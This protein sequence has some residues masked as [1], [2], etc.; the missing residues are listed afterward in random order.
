ML[1]MLT[2]VEEINLPVPPCLGFHWLDDERGWRLRQDSHTG[3]ASLVSY[4]A[5]LDD[6]QDSTTGPSEHI[7]VLYEDVVVP[8]ENFGMTEGGG[9]LGGDAKFS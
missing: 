5:S 4:Y 2:G 3:T 8:P 9:K 7:K 6:S 1:L